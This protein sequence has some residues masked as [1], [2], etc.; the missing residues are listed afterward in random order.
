MR[1][2]WITEGFDAFRAGS[3]GN[4]GQNLYVSKNGVLQRIYQYDLTRNGYFDL[5]FANCQNHHEAAPAFFYEDIFAACPRRTELPA[6]GAVS[7]TVCDLTGS[8]SADLIIAGRYDM[9][10]PFASADIYFGKGGAAYSEQRHIRIPTPWAE[11]SAAGHFDGGKYPTLA[12]SLA[13]YRKIRLFSS[14][15]HGVEWKRFTDLAI[16]AGQLTVAD[17]DGDGCDELIVYDTVHYT[18]TVYWGSADGIRADCFTK[19]PELPENERPVPVISKGLR[20]NMEKELLSPILPRVL[21]LNGQQYLAIASEHRMNFY[22]SC[23]RERFELAFALDAP[24]ALAAAAGDFRGLGRLDLAIAAR[25]AGEEQSQQYSFIYWADADGQ[26][27]ESRRTAVPTEQ[28]CDVLF[29]QLRN[30][31]E[32]D[33]VFCQSHTEYSYDTT[34]PVYRGNPEGRVANP[35]RLPVEDAQR[36]LTVP[37]AGQP[38]ALLFV[39]HYSRSAIGFEKSF[40]YVGGPDGYRP[41]RRIEVPCHCAVD[42]LSC[43]LNDDGRAE[44]VICNNSE[45][46]MHLDVGSHIHFFDA[47][48]NFEP[49]RSR[50]LATHC[51]WGMLA[52]DFRHCGYL[53]LIG[54]CDHFKDLKIFHGSASGYTDENSEVLRLLNP[55]TG[56]HFGSPR[57]IYAADLNGDGWLDLIVPFITHDRT[58]ILWGGPDGFSMERRQELAIWRG[59]CAR[60][61]DLS[62]NGYGDL[63]VGT[64]I[65]TPTAGELAEHMPHESYLHIYW[66]GP[67]GLSDNNKTILRCD[68]A[69]AIC[70]GDFNGDGWLDIFA[71]SYHSGQERDIHSFI[72]WNRQGQFHELDRQELDTHSASGCLAADFNND[73]FIDL[74]VAN[75]KVYGDHHGFSSI[76][77]NGPDGFV[78]QN[79]TDLPTE[80]PHGMSAVEPGNQ[81]TRGAEEYYESTI[82]QLAGE[83]RIAE[84]VVDGEV[85]EN[86]TVAIA[87]RSA[88]NPAELQ[89]A[90]WSREFP[91]GLLPDG[92]L[93]CR[94]FVQ[95]RLTLAARLSLRS[96]RIVRVAVTFEK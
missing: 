51:G 41:D 53:D 74:A 12:F 30:A 32:Q 9:A 78:P 38:D 57:W 93:P 22:R 83:R 36:V 54:V 5:V 18:T 96:P 13:P 47:D 48:G 39:N 27:S 3:F 81:L 17:L 24:H 19:L 84:A 80:G 34:A 2:V 72:Y 95:Y 52:G 75:H 91:P 58:V 76:W 23:G 65:E 33:L 28:A 35:V 43:D 70:V 71:G 15:E 46:S 31:P 59:A 90:A 77:W 69:D 44:L 56:E 66:N 92:G 49:L 82:R 25:S 26:Y 60:V 10:A 88:E 6:Q 61:A 64:H 20:S 63:I 67:D 16:G 45:N 86:C 37:R 8:G 55:Q 11:S 68:A 21:T 89:S 40:I 62:G 85:P 73:G 79:R 87:F 94:K 4:G 1:E 29:A 50:T 14:G 42:S 7:G